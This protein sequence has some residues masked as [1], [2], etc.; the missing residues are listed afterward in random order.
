MEIKEGIK[1]INNNGEKVTIIQVNE[2]F[3]TV[4]VKS[5]VD[6]STKNYSFTTLK[7][8]RRFTQVDGEDQYI[9]EVMQQKKDLGIECPKITE[10]V[11]ELSDVEYAKVG[12]E[13]AEQAKQKAEQVRGKTKVHKSTLPENA[14]KDH[15]ISLAEKYECEV[16]QSN[17]RFISFKT[18]G[19]MFLG[20]FSYSKKCATIG[21]KGEGVK[22]TGLE[23][24]SVMNHSMNY[25]YKFEAV[26]D[27]I[28][29]LF[30]AAMSYQQGVNDKK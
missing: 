13:I 16:C 1:L 26:S 11:A 15:L 24:V 22:D 30:K 5:E 20:L 21:M 17:G 27:D 28:E 3:K 4:I 7:D 10:P 23:P 19:K 14:V 8:K 29:T 6:G 2:K 18:G 12:L 9:A 25:R